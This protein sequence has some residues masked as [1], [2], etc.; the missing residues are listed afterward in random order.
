MRQ[1]VI[2]AG[3]LGTRLRPVTE[4]IPKAMV[5]LYG[6]PFLYWQLQHFKRCG[7]S[8]VVILSGFL[9]EQI[10]QYFGCGDSVGLKIHYSHE[11]TPLGTGGAIIQAMACLDET[12]LLTYGDSYLPIPITPLVAELATGDPL[13]VVA[14][15]LDADHQT[16]VPANITFEPQS[17]KVLSYRKEGGDAYN[18]IEAGLFAFRKAAF[19]ELELQTPVSLEQSILPRLINHGKLLGHVTPQRFYDMGTPAGLLTLSSYLQRTMLL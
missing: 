2:V 9:G 14:L 5:P 3:G 12:F 1:A 15:F 4:A 10:Q 8:N 7:I 16:G 17:R 6:K 18:Y 13:G 19:A 11:T